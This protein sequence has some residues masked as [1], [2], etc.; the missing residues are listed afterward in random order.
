MNLEDVAKY[1]LPPDKTYYQSLKE[2]ISLITTIQSLNTKEFPEEFLKKERKIFPILKKVIAFLSFH[3]KYNVDELQVNFSSTYILCGLHSV[4]FNILKWNEDEIM[5]Y[6]LKEDI[7][8]VLGLSLLMIMNTCFHIDREK[9]TNAVNKLENIPTSPTNPP[10]F[11]KSNLSQSFTLEN[12][13]SKIS[14][15]VNDEGVSSETLSSSYL[16]S[17]NSVANTP[18]LVHSFSTLNNLNSNIP[19]NPSFRVKLKNLAESKSITNL[20]YS[21]SKGN[22]MKD[23]KESGIFLKTVQFIVSS[24][25]YIA[26]RG[27]KV[28]ELYHENI[29]KNQFEENSLIETLTYLMNVSWSNDIKERS[30]C[31]LSFLLPYAEDF[32]GVTDENDENY[33][34]YVGNDN[35][36]DFDEEDF[37]ETDSN[38]VIEMIQRK[39]DRQKDA[40]IKN[41]NT[42][43]KLVRCLLSSQELSAISRGCNSVNYIGKLLSFF[44]FF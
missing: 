41:T 34:V 24:L 19:S 21:E 7:I 39:I 4:I 11:R 1:D 42:I 6:L 27:G 32:W 5:D 43:L 33:D 30:A 16:F 10:S 25:E 2:T 37:E 28:T 31:S 23:G 22:P 40:S 29:Y 20:L 12:I 14:S 8:G 26:V 38:T 44:F 15:Q 18:V 3:S 35:Y 36:S 17:S 13:N 9:V